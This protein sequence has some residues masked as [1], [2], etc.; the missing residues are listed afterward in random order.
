MLPASKFNEDQLVLIR[1]AI[2]GE[3]Y[4]LHCE[5]E[6]IKGIPDTNLL[7]KIGGYPEKRK[8]YKRDMKILEQV[9]E[10]INNYFKM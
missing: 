7:S 1:R 2:S 8:V 10:I 5:L 9:N 4:E 3:F 6:K